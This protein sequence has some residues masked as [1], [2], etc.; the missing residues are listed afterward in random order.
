MRN[1]R[2]LL[3]IILIMTSSIVRPQKFTKLIDYVD[4]DSV[5]SD[6]Q[7][8]GNNSKYIKNVDLV[9]VLLLDS[10]YR[11]QI[12]N[13]EPESVRLFDRVIGYKR[14]QENKIVITF[15]ATDIRHAFDSK[16]FQKQLLSNCAKGQKNSNK[17]LDSKI[18]I[19]DSHNGLFIVN[20]ESY[21]ECYCASI[22]DNDVLINM[23][24][25]I[26]E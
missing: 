4:I 16:K 10:T 20:G 22:S 12:E 26:Q 5:M 25:K 8:N 17:E 14:F 6:I 21:Q 3:V 11:V 24:Y 1:F 7:L 9:F 15:K 19:Q 23:I 18:Y 2:I 13:I